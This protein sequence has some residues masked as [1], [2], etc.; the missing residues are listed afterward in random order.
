MHLYNTIYIE[1]RIL[2]YSD[3]SS[4]FIVQPYFVESFTDPVLLEYLS[5]MLALL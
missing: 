2:N 4:C 5:F 3:L 1:S